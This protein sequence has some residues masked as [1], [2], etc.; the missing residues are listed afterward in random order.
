LGLGALAASVAADTWEERV[1][2]TLAA[3][4]EGALSKLGRLSR[5][6]RLR[7]QNRNTPRRAGEK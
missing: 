1:D 3:T 4:D 2:A 6:L 5:R 7:R